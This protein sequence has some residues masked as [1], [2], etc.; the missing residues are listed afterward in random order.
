MLKVCCR[1]VR[2][3]VLVMQSCD[4]NIVHCYCVL[5]RLVNALLSVRVASFKQNLSLIFVAGAI[6]ALATKII[7]VW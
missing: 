7:T 2:S 5:F 6:S 3:C 1:I 4:R